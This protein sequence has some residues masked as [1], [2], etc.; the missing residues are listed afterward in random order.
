MRKAKNDWFLTPEE[1][2]QAMANPVSRF[3]NMVS[4]ADM[5]AEV[6]DLLAEEREWLQSLP[7]EKRQYILRE[8]NEMIDEK[9]E[10]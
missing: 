8:V 10:I 1:W 2:K 9:P 6:A 3:L 4:F 7:R 5:Q